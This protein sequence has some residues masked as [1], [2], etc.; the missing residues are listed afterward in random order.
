MDKPSVILV[1]GPTASGK[2]AVS[3][4]IAKSINGEIISA[5][6]MQ[7]YRQMNIGTA[8]PSEEEKQSITHYLIDEVDVDYDF[9]VA[10]FKDRANEL[11][12][13]ILNRGKIPVLCGGTG[14]YINS[15][16]Y[17]LN[18]GKTSANTVLREKLYKIADEKGTE[19]LH[20]LLKEKSPSAALR[21]HPNNTKRIVRALELLEGEA[22]EKEFN[23]QKESDKY[24][25]IMIG[26]KMDRK[27]LYDRINDRVDKMI[28]L[29]LIGE[30]RN[31][32]E[33]CGGDCNAFSAIGYKEFIDYFKGSL[34]LEDVVSNIKQATRRY[35]KRQITWF[36][37]DKRIK[38]FDLDLYKDFN[39]F[40]NDIIKYT[41][42][43]LYT[44]NTEKD[45]G[46]Y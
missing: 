46:N 24:S 32:Y 15:I 16:T 8:K 28:S 22:V 37:R 26:I 27:K 17:S 19:Y 4:E 23:F 7:I 18:F 41:K 33:R 9:S 3:I 11:I 10:M 45:I 43:L 2:T 30:V 1:V 35:A 20:N 6:S 39:D 25:F 42:N 14:L 12:V 13:D 21:I 29:G 5:D 44:E 40:T 38:W 31:I 36:K 34:S